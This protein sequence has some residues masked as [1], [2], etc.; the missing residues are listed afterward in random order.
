MLSDVF[1][2]K[3]AVVGISQADALFSLPMK[4]AELGIS[5][6]NASHAASGYQAG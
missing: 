6:I 4:L 2:I 3:H 5:T 1:L